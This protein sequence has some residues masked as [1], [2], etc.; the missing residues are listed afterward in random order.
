[1]VLNNVGGWVWAREAVPGSA[2][3][4]GGRTCANQTSLTPSHPS[5]ELIEYT[6]A[7]FDRIEELSACRILVMCDG[8]RKGLCSVQ[9]QPFSLLLRIIFF[10]C[11][12]FVHVVSVADTRNR[13]L[14]LGEVRRQTQS[15][16]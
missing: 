16:N 13:F 10:C 15:S 8:W 3:I 12:L 11:S 6:V 4:H 2:R 9:P 14:M 5:T 7:S 1:M